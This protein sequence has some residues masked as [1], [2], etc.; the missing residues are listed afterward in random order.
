MCENSSSQYILLKKKEYD[1]EKKEF[2]ILKELNNI[3]KKSIE[4]FNDAKSVK[5]FGIN[6]IGDVISFI[7]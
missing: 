5:D 7:T 6:N 3:Y 1:D 2:F 4:K